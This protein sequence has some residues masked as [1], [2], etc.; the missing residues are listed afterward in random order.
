[1][2]P[3]G[4]APIFDS[5]GAALRFARENW[6]FVLMVAAISAG[7]QALAMLALGPTL[8]WFAVLGLASAAANAALIAAALH[9]AGAVRAR[10]VGDTGRVAAAMAMVGFFIALIAFLAIYIAMSVMIAPYAEEVK[11]AGQDQA[12]LMEIMNHAAEAQ[13]NVLSW[14]LLLA[15]AAIFALTSRFY[16]AAPASVD[17]KRIVVF[18]SWRWTRG[19]LLRIVAARLMLLAPALIFVGALQSLLAMAMGVAAGDAMA[20]AAYGQSNPAVFALFFG[21]A[22]FVHIAI[23]SSLEAGLSSYLYRGLR[24]PPASAG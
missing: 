7:A 8:I 16:L 15:G 6:R 2:A 12:Q 9:G 24:P 21:V 10:L 3:A 23:Y 22:S 14:A 20:L 4:K 19:N 1:M 17:E 5:I 13:P 18:E 11:A